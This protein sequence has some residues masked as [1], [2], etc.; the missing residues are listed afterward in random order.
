[1]GQLL[2]CWT[3]MRGFLPLLKLLLEI[4]ICFT[5]YGICFV[6]ALFIFLVA[7]SLLFGG[8]LCIEIFFF[9]RSLF[10]VVV[11]TDETATQI[12]RHLNASKGGRVTFIPLNKVKP[13]HIN[14]PQSD[15]VVP[16]LKKLKFQEMYTKA[17][18]QV[19]ILFLFF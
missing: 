3:V 12:I 17:F 13:A 10:H 7:K 14:C 5:S 4:G 19:S 9:W 8:L 6:N 1:M 18:S 16:L 15:D 11:D 2:N